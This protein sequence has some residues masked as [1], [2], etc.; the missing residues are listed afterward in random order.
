MPFQGF[1]G[2]AGTG[3]THRLVE[4][5]V[6][7]V[8]ANPLQPYQQILALTFMHGS[9]RRLDQRL[10][11]LPAL[12]GRFCC[13]TIDSLAEQITGRWK[14]LC[15]HHGIQTGTFE[16]T[17]ACAA[18]LLEQPI[19]AHWVASSFPVVVIDEA[20]ELTPAR[21]RMVKALAGHTKCFAAADEFQCLDENLDPEPFRSWFATGNITQLTQVRRTGQQ[22]LLNA[23]IALRAGAAPVNG[24]GLK[25]KY[26]F[27]NQA[28]F[29]IGHELHRGLSNGGN[30]ALIVAPSAKAWADQLIPRLL[31]GFSSSRQ[32]IPPLRLGWE[33]RP[34]EEVTQVMAA[35]PPGESILSEAVLNSFAGLPH[36][37]PWLSD[38]VGAIKHQRRACG[39]LAWTRF[40]LQGLMERKAAI[41]R[42]YGHSGTKGIPVMTI[43]GAKNRQF[44]HV[45]VLWQPGVPGS[46]NHKRRLLYNAITRAE[47]SCAVF[48]RTEAL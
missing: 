37:P 33:T 19:V 34:D 47:Q 26:E 9:R 12:R 41:H 8:T 45:V 2:P 20:Q 14:S 22:G 5:I 11:L 28:P 44:K 27:K 36:M 29:S 17:V 31:A 24:A 3:K 30:V 46:D 32:T 15:N 40:A 43:H 39:Q 6:A 38:V 4:D 1:E 23:A 25:I 48:V 21:L 13:M 42:A 18:F 10:S 7:W 16:E 35:I